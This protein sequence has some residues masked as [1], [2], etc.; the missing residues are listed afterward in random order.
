MKDLLCQG[1]LLVARFHR[2]IPKV[3]SL[4]TSLASSHSGCRGPPSVS[5]SYTQLYNESFADLLEPNSA[6]AADLKLICALPAAVTYRA[7][8][9][10]SFI[11]IVIVTLNVIIDMLQVDRR[12]VC[13]GAY[14]VL[15]TFEAIN[16]TN[17][18]GYLYATSAVVNA[19]WPDHFASVYGFC[20]AFS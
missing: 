5:V 3:V 19:A 14:G 18:V 13:A 1:V 15:E 8:A 11:I 20:H 17:H 6:A 9:V 4:S 16:V 10:I 12:S 2:W 7:P